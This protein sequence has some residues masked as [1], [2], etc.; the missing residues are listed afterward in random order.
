MIKS[1]CQFENLHQVMGPDDSVYRIVR[2]Q[3]KDLL[4]NYRDSREI[5]FKDFERFKDFAQF[6]A[7]IILS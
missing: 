3:V 1:Y 7:K 2:K 4:S 5:R 6:D